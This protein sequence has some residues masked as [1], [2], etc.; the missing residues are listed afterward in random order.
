MDTMVPFV[1][2]T[3]TFT[4]KNTNASNVYK[5]YTGYKGVYAYDDVNV[6]TVEK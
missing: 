1:E 3:T 2:G 6:Y 5:F 4:F